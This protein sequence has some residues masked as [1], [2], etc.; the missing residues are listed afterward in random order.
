MMEDLL[1]SQS[2]AGLESPHGTAGTAM[3]V[4]GDGLARFYELALSHESLREKFLAII[5][6]GKAHQVPRT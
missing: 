3:T 6:A 5:N 2:G 4:Q 1:L